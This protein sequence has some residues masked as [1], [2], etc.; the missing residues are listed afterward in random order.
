MRGLTVGGEL[1]AGDRRLEEGIAA[2]DIRN[3]YLGLRY[4]FARAHIGVAY[5][6]SDQIAIEDNDNVARQLDFELGIIF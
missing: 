5:W 4:S 6:H 3:A 2:K 1:I